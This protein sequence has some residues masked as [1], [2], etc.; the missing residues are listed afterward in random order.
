MNV[1]FLMKKG[2]VVIVNVD[3]WVVCGKYSYLIT[4]FPA[5]CLADTDCW[6]SNVVVVCS[7]CVGNFCWYTV[8]AIC[9]Y[10]SCILN[11]CVILLLF[12]RILV[13]V[14]RRAAW[15]FM[16]AFCFVGAMFLVDFHRLSCVMSSA[17]EACLRVSNIL[18]FGKVGSACECSIAL[19]NVGSICLAT[20]CFACFAN[21]LAS[22]FSADVAIDLFCVVCRFFLCDSLS[23]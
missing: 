15:F 16:I 4:Y 12:C 2:I 19:C 20:S 13:S 9:V 6:V 11:S 10:L 5:C 22:I 18:C 1:L 7:R 21:T 8:S 3:S 23:C 17:F 14:R